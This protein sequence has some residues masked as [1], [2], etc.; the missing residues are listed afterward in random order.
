MN[1]YIGHVKYINSNNKKETG[2]VSI[3]LFEL[4]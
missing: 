1:L 4:N 2:F 3:L